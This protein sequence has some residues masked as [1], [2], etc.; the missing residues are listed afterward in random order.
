L[1]KNC[2]RLIGVIVD[3]LQLRLLAPALEAGNQ[4]GPGLEV[5]LIEGRLLAGALD[6]ALLPHI[7]FEHLDPLGERL[8]IVGALRRGLE[9]AFL[10]RPSRVGSADREASGNRHGENPVNQGSGS[11]EA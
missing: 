8:E 3:R 2:P 7:A 9:E 10:L 11:S 1:A 5:A 6:L 4:P